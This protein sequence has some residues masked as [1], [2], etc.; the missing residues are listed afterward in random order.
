MSLF[1]T[2]SLSPSHLLLVSKS[3][4]VMGA[5]SSF[6][7]GHMKMLFSILSRYLDRDV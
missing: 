5:I 3:N 6:F 2:S 4:S 1:S 7:L